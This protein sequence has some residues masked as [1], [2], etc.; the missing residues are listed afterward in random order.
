MH[1]L[2]QLHPTELLACEETQKMPV[3]SEIPV[4]KNRFK[5]F[6]QAGLA[7]HLPQFIVKVG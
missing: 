7:V 3:F 1:P 2:P 4:Q 6:W 5:L